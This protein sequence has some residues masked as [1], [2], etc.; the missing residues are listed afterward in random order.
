MDWQEVFH[1]G[2]IFERRYQVK[3]EHAASHVGSGSAPVLATPWMI[4]FMEQVSR[5]LLAQHLPEGYSS[6]GVHLDVHH[7]APTPVGLDVLITAEVLRVNKNRVHF[8][9]RAQDDVEQVGEGMHERVIIDEDRFMRR[10]TEK[11]AGR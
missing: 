9:V 7:L 3:P 11:A 8:K 10:V 6:V 1:P 5:D 4:A 2:M